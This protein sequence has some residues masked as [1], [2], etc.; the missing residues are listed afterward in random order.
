MTSRTLVIVPNRS[1]Y[2]FGWCLE[3]AIRTANAGNDVYFTDFSHLD[4]RYATKPLLWSIDKI[5][6]RDSIHKNIGKIAKKHNFTY[7]PAKRVNSSL[8]EVDDSNI[9]VFIRSLKS[10]YARWYGRIDMPIN[11]IPENIFTAEKVSFNNCYKK[12]ID[13]IHSLN[14]ST[15]VTVNGRFVSDSAIVAASTDLNIEYIVLERKAPYRW[16]RMS[17]FRISTQSITENRQQLE[18]CWVNL[19]EENRISAINLAERHFQMRVG[20]D[21]HW[22]N[23]QRKGASLNLPKKFI[24]FFTTTE[25]EAATIKLDID[26]PNNLSQHQVFLALSKYCSEKNLDLVVRV[27]PHPKEPN[28]ALLE[29]QIWNDLNENGTA[30]IIKSLDE[31]DSLQ[32]AKMSLMNVVYRSSMGAELVYLELPVVMTGPTAFS[33]LV[34]DL[35]AGSIEELLI[36]IDQQSKPGPRQSVYP[37]AYYNEQAGYEIQ[38]VKIQSDSVINVDGIEFGHTSK[39]GKFI[40]FLLSQRRRKPHGIAP[41]APQ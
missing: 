19:G 1:I 21:W 3:Y 35:E 7:I 32:I 12:T 23:K 24:C 28:L 40:N 36:R 29:D 34:E 4:S 26:P 41:R 17:E 25:I 11:A 6:M 2:V 33:H 5:R 10:R 31:T 18:E 39:F 13:L 30:I 38:N 37:W 22:R 9:P 8:T 20:E 14:I 16:D 15:V 27:H